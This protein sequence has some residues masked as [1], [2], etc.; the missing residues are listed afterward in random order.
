VDF[1]HSPED[2]AFR[3]E[4]RAWLEENL[5]KFLADWG[6][7]EAD[8]PVA[9]ASSGSAA[10]V[11]Q[12]AAAAGGG[13]TGGTTSSVSRSQERRRDWQ[14]RLNE[15]RW[16]AINWPTEWGGREATPVQNVIHAEE[17]ARARAPGIYNANG[18][19]QIGPMIIK[20]GTDE[21][22]QRWLPGILDASE[23][24]CQ[25]FSEPEAG[26]DLANL[27]TTATRD[28][29]EYIVNGQ[30]IWISTAHLA[31]WGLF[32]LRTDPGAIERGAKHEGI[33]AFI[34]NMHTPG[35]ECRP[36][37]DIAGDEL[38]NEVW[39][40]DAR[41]PI[42]CRLGDE[43][44]GWQVAMGTLGH[45]RVGT[46][47]LAITMAADLRSMISAA[48]AT[49]PDAVRDPEIRERVARA[50]TDI[51]YTKL[52]NYRALTK[53]I[54]G[55]KNWPEVPLAKLQWSY[56]AQT[57]A[58]LAVDLLG[59]AGVLAKGGPDAVDGGTWTRLY[60]RRRHRG[61][62]EH[63]RRPRFVAAQMIARWVVNR[64]YTPCF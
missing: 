47:G 27:R 17:N 1:A 51:E 59:P 28:G 25:G 36:I 11:G 31:D 52:L 20:W 55:E 35:I 56:L 15:G 19:W 37:R 46:A 6:G 5:P 61:A 54:K 33:T 18:I 3:D 7:D 44:Q 24:W 63:H 39:F 12:A 22:K 41:V 62:K 29:D 10:A 23:H 9:V 38:F 4:L 48:K 26:S 53:I 49:N 60:R 40:T 13:R 58:E 8:P 57:L 34:V 50:F 16:A 64:G 30:K 2:I 14:R 43:G 42:D 21:Q 32:L 45:E